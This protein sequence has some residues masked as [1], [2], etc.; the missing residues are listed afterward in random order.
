[1]E[2]S[3]AFGT[4][5]DNVIAAVGVTR[6][7]VDLG[8]AQENSVGSG[9]T[10]TTSNTPEEVV[11]LTPV[12]VKGS[13]ADFQNQVT[14]TERLEN[15]QNMLDQGER[16]IGSDDWVDAHVHQTLRFAG[17]HVGELERAAAQKAIWVGKP[18]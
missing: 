17:P 10:A 7:A 18:L 8:G 9:S 12:E 14:E 1:L 6:T 13:R 16:W 11:K 5:I 3:T 2:A 15:F 4:K